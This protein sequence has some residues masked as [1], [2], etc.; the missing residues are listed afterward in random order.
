MAARRKGENV[1]G[2]QGAVVIT[3]A[4][5]QVGSAI[6]QHL[7]GR[8][9]L[10]LIGHGA[11]EKAS[12]GAEVAHFAADLGDESAT[13]RLAGDIRARFGRVRALVH[14]VGGW[15]GGVPV[16]K[17]PLA[18]V[19]KMLDV[20]FISAVHVTKALLPDILA[21]GQGRIVFFASADA[22]RARAGNA[23]YA[24]S[25][26]ALLRFAEALSEEVASAGVCVRV[27]APTTIDTKL[28]REAMPSA[29]FADWV[30]LPEI[31]ETVAFLLDPAS[32][33]VRFAT[34]PMGR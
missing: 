22:L 19:R 10:A 4:S 32:S 33:G 7:V 24:A 13:E 17:Q 8:A 18:T 28:N 9:P 25:K 12:A 1:S 6:A 27:L 2:E 34:I 14:T 26:A 23:A 21:A 16:E 30:T 31:V 15:T 11:T 20:N 29:R 3:G 5:G